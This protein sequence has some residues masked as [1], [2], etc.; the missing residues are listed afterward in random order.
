M[1]EPSFSNVQTDVRYQ[2]C[3]FPP[4]TEWSDAYYSAGGTARFACNICGKKFL[5]P[6]SLKHHRSAHRGETQCPVCHIVLSRIFNLKRHILTMHQ[7]W[8]AVSNW[9]RSVFKRTLLSS[10][11]TYVTVSFCITPRMWIVCCIG[12]HQ[13]F[14]SITSENMAHSAH[15]QFNHRSKN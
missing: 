14:Y 13:Q 7:Q 12:S 10:F 11:G 2:S 8:F 3:F 5:H 15:C 6:D 9:L 4:T 1:L